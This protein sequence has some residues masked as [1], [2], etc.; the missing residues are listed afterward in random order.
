[1]MTIDEMRE[2]IESL[3]SGLQVDTSDLRQKNNDILRGCGNELLL[4]K[5]ELSGI[6]RYLYSVNAAEDTDGGVAKRLRGRSS[7]LSSICHAFAYELR[8]HVGFDSEKTLLAAGGKFLVVFP[9]SEDVKRKVSSWKKEIDEWLWERAWN[10]LSLNLAWLKCNQRDLRSD[11]SLEVALPLQELLDKN[12]LNKFLP[13]LRSGI[14]KSETGWH[15]FPLYK[16]N[17]A[18]EC[19]SCK[20]L[21]A[22]MTVVEGERNLCEVCIRL[23][24]LGGDLA[25]FDKCSLE[26]HE[27]E[28]EDRPSV[29]NFHQTYAILKDSTS[30]LLPQIA[31]FVPQWPYYGLNQVETAAESAQ[32]SEDCAN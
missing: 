15:S 23:Q 32:I 7:Y 26:F 27:G 22:K 20:H 16:E 28:A 1:M 18:D 10:E 11:F 9:Y 13:L 17:Y 24:R 31:A 5:G 29:V 25:S 3:A 21:P 30:T 14:E 2:L 8:Y 19:H 6:Q 4:V 12:A